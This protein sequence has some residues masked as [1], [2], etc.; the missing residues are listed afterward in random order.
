MGMEYESD[1]ESET[2]TME[3]I[4]ETDWRMGWEGVPQRG[5]KGAGMHGGEVGARM[6]P[7]AWE[8]VLLIFGG[9]ALHP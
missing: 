9:E 5:K 4:R 2:N 1:N 7:D 6:R 3:K 8:A